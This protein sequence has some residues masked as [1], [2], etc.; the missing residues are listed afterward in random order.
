MADPAPDERDFFAAV[1]LYTILW[2]QL[3]AGLDFI[4]T[5]VHQP[6][7]GD[8]IE[9]ELPRA[10]QR[11]LDYLRKAFQRLAPLAPYQQRAVDLVANIIAASETR[12][13]LIHGC[14]VSRPVGQTVEAEMFRL[15]WEKTHYREKTLTIGTGDIIAASNRVR[16]LAYQALILA[17][18]MVKAF[19]K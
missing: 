18:A 5:I 1:G 15:L 8:Q 7:G 13:D 4:A 14:L 10:L 6:L 9:P 2:A 3:E 11:K 16:D 17:D 12:H 19:L